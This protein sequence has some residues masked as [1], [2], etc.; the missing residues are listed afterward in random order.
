MQHDRSPSPDLMMPRRN[1]RSMIHHDAAHHGLCGG[2]LGSWM[3]VANPHPVTL[4][5]KH[6]ID[7]TAVQYSTCADTYCTSVM[8]QETERHP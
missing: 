2:R 4:P 8:Q 1:L 5:A 3:M 7:G 6:C